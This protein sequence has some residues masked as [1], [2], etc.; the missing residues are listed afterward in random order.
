[1]NYGRRLPDKYFQ[2]TYIWDTCHI[3]LIFYRVPSAMCLST[4]NIKKTDWSVLVYNVMDSSEFLI[5]NIL[6]PIAV[7]HAE[8]ISDRIKLGFEMF[9]SRYVL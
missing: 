4:V 8:V 2:H 5:R 6:V 7:S 1:M 3:N 9:L